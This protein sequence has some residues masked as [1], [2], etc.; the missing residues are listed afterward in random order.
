MEEFTMVGQV[1]SPRMIPSLPDDN[2]AFDADERRA[3][4]ADTIQKVLNVDDVLAEVDYLLADL[5]GPQ[6]P[7]YALAAHCV[8]QGTTQQTGKAPWM[9]ENVGAALEP[10][11][12]QAIE[13]LVA[14][15]LGEV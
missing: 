13:R 3:E 15:A 8:R 1:F 12:A 10:Y 14:R 6:H 4:A 7:L 11:I 9:A 2:P 5:R